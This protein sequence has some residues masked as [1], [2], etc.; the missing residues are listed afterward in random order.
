MFCLLLSFWF[1]FD[2]IVIVLSEWIIFVLSL[3]VAFGIKVSARCDPMGMILDTGG[4]QGSCSTRESR[5]RI[6][7]G[8]PNPQ[9]LG[10]DRQCR[11]QAPANEEGCDKKGVWRR[12][13]AKPLFVLLSAVAT[14]IRICRRVNIYQLL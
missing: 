14:Q 13:S 9:P 7:V 5:V 6:T 1:L 10:I 11:S 4:Y 12:S 2:L 3:F 8:V